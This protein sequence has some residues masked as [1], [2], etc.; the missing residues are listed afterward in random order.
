MKLTAL[1][2]TLKPLTPLYVSRTSLVHYRRQ[3]FTVSISQID[4]FKGQN[5]LIMNIKVVKVVQMLQTA[6]EFS[7]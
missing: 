6:E 4:N 7:D 3:V 1:W 2:S 5:E